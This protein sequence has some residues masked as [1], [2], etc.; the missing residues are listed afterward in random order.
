M[1][2]RAFGLG[3]SRLAA[4]FLTFAVPAGLIGCGDSADQTTGSEVV[5]DP[6]A[7]K[8]QDDMTKYYAK[9]P[10]PKPKK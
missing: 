2:R 5:P 4:L 1:N 10:L 6:E 3:A 9:N 8:R 7:A